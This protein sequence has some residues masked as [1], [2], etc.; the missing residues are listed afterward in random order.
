M[1]VNP[2]LTENSTNATTWKTLGTGQSITIYK[3]TYSGNNT[4]SSTASR[5]G[6]N[7]WLASRSNYCNSYAVYYDIKFVY[8]ASGLMDAYSVYNSYGSNIEH[9][10]LGFRPVVY[11][12]STAKLSNYSSTNGYTLRYS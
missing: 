4:L 8:A 3:Y 1:E 9:T 2:N 12:K 5:T 6:K 7:Y 10:N 11:L